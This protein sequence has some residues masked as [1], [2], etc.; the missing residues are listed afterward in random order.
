LGPPGALG[1]R[2]VSA[3][4]LRGY[5]FAAMVVAQETGWLLLAQRNHFA[6]GDTLELL[7]PEGG[8]I[9]FTVAQLFDG[10]GRQIRA[11]AHPGM[12]VWLPLTAAQE[13]M[14][15]CYQPPLVIRRPVAN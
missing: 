15:S 1:Q 12:Q 14:L 6:V 9:D 7:L 3:D 8:Q 11:A 4:P 13:Q 2:Y 5:D 10:E